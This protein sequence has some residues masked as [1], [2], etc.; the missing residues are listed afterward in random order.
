[1]DPKLPG[2]AVCFY[3]FRL[4]R[5]ILLAIFH[6]SLAKLRLEVGSKLDAI[7]RIDVNH[8]HFTG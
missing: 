1:M 2:I 7:R 3:H 8:L 4:T 6:I 5:Q